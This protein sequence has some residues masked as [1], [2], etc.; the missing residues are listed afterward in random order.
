[1]KKIGKENN[2]MIITKPI[3]SK[4]DCLEI[5]QNNYLKGIRNLQINMRKLLI[6]RIGK[7]R[8]LA[9]YWIAK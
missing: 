3:Y 7:K 8:S 9:I 5:L 4:L 1:L 2:E 6:I